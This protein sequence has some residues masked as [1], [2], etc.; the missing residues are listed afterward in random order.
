MLAAPVYTSEAELQGD[1]RVCKLEL[2]DG[3]P[4]GLLAVYHREDKRLLV[5]I[6]NQSWSIVHRDY[7][8]GG[9]EAEF[10]I[11]L[12]DPWHGMD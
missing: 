8:E 12:T 9:F 4:E 10:Q 5:A 11:M 1:E 3:T 7:P 6:T 2:P